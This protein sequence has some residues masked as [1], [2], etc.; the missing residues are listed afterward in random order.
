[1]SGDGPDRQ[2]GDDR[3]EDQGVTSPQNSGSQ[4]AVRGQDK[5]PPQQREPSGNPAP[6][7]GQP[8]QSE[9]H[10]QPTASSLT[11]R[12]Q[13]PEPMHYIKLTV[14]IFA[15]A[16]FGYGL[17]AFLFTAFSDTG[18]TGQS[19]V[20]GFTVLFGLL[21]GPVVAIISGTHIGFNLEEDDTTASAASVVGAGVGFLLM[22][23]ILILFAAMMSSGGGGDGGGGTNLGPAIGAMIGVGVTGGA[24]TFAIRK[25][26]SRRI[27]KTGDGQT[28]PAP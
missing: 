1:M 11:D 17:T 10:H 22:A 18:A 3:V 24:A 26:E 4:D 9:Q 27:S 8:V 12:L 16:G 15:V 19:L 7:R 23:I 2:D 14:A 28:G 21:L 25:V 20:G 6:R 5:T 13:Q